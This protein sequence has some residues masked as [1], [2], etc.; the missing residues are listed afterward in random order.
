[1]KL[2]TKAHREKLLANGTRRGADHKP[3]VRLF[4]PRE[5]APG[6]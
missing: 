6:C 2:F 4:N 3:V 5:R 1:M